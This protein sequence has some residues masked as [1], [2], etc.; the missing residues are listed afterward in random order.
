[1]DQFYIESGYFDQGYFAYTAEAEANISVSASIACSVNASVNFQATLNCVASVSAII[2]HI[3]GADIVLAPF[4]SLSI[5]NERV[6][7]VAIGGTSRPPK[8]ISVFGNT[9]VSTTQSKF[10]LGSIVFDGTGDYLKINSNS[11][12]QFGTGDFTVEGWAYRATTGV[13]VSLFDFRSAATQTAPWLYIGTGGSLLYVVNSSNRISTGSGTIGA[14]SW[15]HVAVSRSGTDTRVFVNGTQAGS[16]YTDTNNYIQSPLTIGSRYTGANEFFNG[17]IDELRVTKGLARYTSNFTAP[18]AAFVNDGDTVLLIHGDT[19]ITD[20]PGSSGLLTEFTFASATGTNIKQLESA[21]SSEVNLIVD[22]TRTREAAASINDA[23]TFDATVDIIE[24][25]GEVVQASGDWYVE[26]TQTTLGGK[27]FDNVI[28]FDGYV[29]DA[30]AEVGYVEDAGVVSS[31]VITAANLITVEAQLSVE[32][33]VVTLE[34]KIKNAD[35]NIFAEF[36]AS[37]VSDIITAIEIFAFAEA[38]LAVEIARVRFYEIESSSAFDIATD[39]VRFRDTF[40]D[41]ES[42]FQTD[43]TSERSRDYVSDIQAAFSFDATI[44]SIKEFE[45]DFGALFTPDININVRINNFAALD[46]EFAL[47][48]EILRIKDFSVD[49]GFYVDPNY[50]DNGY[51]SEDGARVTVT[52]VGGKQLNASATVESVASLSAIPT[53]T[54]DTSVAL[55]AVFAQSSDVIRVRFADSTQSSEFTVLADI[56]LIGSVQLNASVETTMT[57][58]AVVIRD[59]QVEFES[60]ATNLASVAY[61]GDFLVTLQSQF[62]IVATGRVITGVGAAFDM[63]FSTIANVNYIAENTASAQVSANLVADTTSVYAGDIELSTTASLSADNGRIRNDSAAFD[64]VASN[65]A[66]V[67][68]ITETLAI[69]AGTFT[70]E[71]TAVKTTDILVNAQSEITL[72]SSGE[73]VRYQSAQADSEFNLN[74]IVRKDTEAA[75]DAVVEFSASIVAEKNAQFSANIDSAMAFDIFA[76]ATKVGESVFEV[77]STL[78]STAQKITDVFS[79]FVLTT[80]QN[81]FAVKTVDVDTSVSFTTE[82]TADINV[83]EQLE[84]NVAAEFTQTSTAVKTVEAIANISD[85]AVFNSTVVA[86]RNNE[87]IAQVS[88]QLDVTISRIRLSG[89]E[90]SSQTTV[91][92]V[93]VKNVQADSAINSTAS[94]VANGR[95]IVIDKYE[96]IIPREYREF[97]I[98]AENRQYRIVKENREHIVRG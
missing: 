24:A 12:F 72:T 64:A 91:N 32:T 14:G 97:A 20:D 11:D 34:Q 1:M 43:A 65:L 98:H 77:T 73:R 96:Y 75:L 8:N 92:A 71:S 82:I 39:F 50:V 25:L 95:I 48:A 31:I 78:D 10:G 42:V 28:V 67:A 89:S 84:A 23:L 13:A 30:Y 17:Y 9:A 54:V 49:V 45:C 59:A 57:A 81:S 38:Q 36:T 5:N 55:E 37:G 68:K 22:N 52:A 15:Y 85:A 47:Q 94:V 26:T 35:A 53:I 7:N 66:I 2:S 44:G 56:D 80:E 63:A 79:E 61:I 90:Q 76:V 29:E 41:A 21:V 87:I 83:I 18:T 62:D 93:V 69:T 4:A 40:A 19:D 16:T 27:L 3:E 51:A 88:T 74:G 70:F 33:T 60:I 86:I 6:R 46:S 58:S